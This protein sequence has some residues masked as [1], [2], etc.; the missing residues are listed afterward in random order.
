M[1]V[2]SAHCSLRILIS[3]YFSGV[4]IL[5]TDYGTQF[6]S[7]NGDF[8]SWKIGIEAKAVN[9]LADAFVYLRDF[10]KFFFCRGTV[11]I[12]QDNAYKIKRFYG[13]AVPFIYPGSD[14]F[15]REFSSDSTGLTKNPQTI[16]S[17]SRFVPYKGFHLLV[18]IFKSL[19]ATYPNAKLVLVGGQGYIKVL[20][21][22]PPAPVGRGSV[23]HFWRRPV[24]D[25]R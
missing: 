8:G 6:P 9:F 21:F 15:L 23:C 25:C 7:L 3:A 19:E 5:R 24:S 16:L 1:D 4:P 22:M 11:A 2:I 12:S 17:V 10:L 18:N 20:A 14:D 13:R